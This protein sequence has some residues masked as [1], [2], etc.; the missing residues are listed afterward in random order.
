[1]KGRKERKVIEIE[2]PN[3]ERRHMAAA[4]AGGHDEC[5]IVHY[6]C[7]TWIKLTTNYKLIQFIDSVWHK[8]V[9]ST[10]EAD[11]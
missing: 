1:M 5:R 6:V 3:G 7:F 11:T 9:C 4:V 2:E 8:S 10:C